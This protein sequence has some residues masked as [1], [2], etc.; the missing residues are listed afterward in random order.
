[1]SPIPQARRIATNVRQEHDSSEQP[2]LHKIKGRK[3]WGPMVVSERRKLFEQLSGSY[4]TT[5]DTEF[6]A[7]WGLPFNT[8]RLR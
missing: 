5:P 6:H 7:G 4:Y 3:G 1:V 8:D 2:R